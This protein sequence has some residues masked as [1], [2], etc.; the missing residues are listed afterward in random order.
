VEQQPKPL[1][2]HE[3]LKNALAKR[4]FWRKA[5]ADPAQTP[6]TAAAAIDLAKSWDAA[7]LGYQKA[8]MPPDEGR[9]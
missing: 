7:A 9:R 8:L 3:K 5:A 1:S 2:T 4:D 6:S